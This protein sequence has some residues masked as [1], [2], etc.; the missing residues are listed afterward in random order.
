M[1]DNL[2]HGCFDGCGR[3]RGLLFPLFLLLLD[4]CHYGHHS[5]NRRCHHRRRSYCHH[6]R[7]FY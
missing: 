1:F 6:R 5:F 3:D 4:D 7:H 2:F